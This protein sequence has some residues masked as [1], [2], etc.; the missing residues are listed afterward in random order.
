MQFHNQ[1]Q[2][3]RSRSH[4]QKTLRK[5]HFKN[6]HDRYSIIMKNYRSSLKRN[7]QERESVPRLGKLFRKGF[8]VNLSVLIC[9]CAWVANMHGIINLDLA[10]FWD[11]IN[12][13]FP[14]I[15]FISTTLWQWLSINIPFN[16]KF[17]VTKNIYHEF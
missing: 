6:T 7:T 17:L 4:M 3:K 2:W 11:Y 10:L 1:K 5:S 14:A 16:L 12:N 15:F 9:L 13:F 8:C